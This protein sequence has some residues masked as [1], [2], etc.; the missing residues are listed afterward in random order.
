[1]AGEADDGLRLEAENGETICGRFDR[2]AKLD[3]AA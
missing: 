2:Y 1:L 3:E